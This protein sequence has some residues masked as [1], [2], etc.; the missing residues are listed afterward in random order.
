MQD[1]GGVTGGANERQCRPE[2]VRVGPQLC[3]GSTGCKVRH[4]SPDIG[5]RLNGTCPLPCRGACKEVKSQLLRRVRPAVRVHGTTVASLG[6][7]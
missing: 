7:Q 5:L 4:P 3:W 6:A 2:E 1:N